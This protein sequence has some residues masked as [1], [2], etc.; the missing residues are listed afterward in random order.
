MSD[1]KTEIVLTVR[2][3][4]SRSL[5]SVLCD[6]MNKEYGG[7]YMR[8]TGEVLEFFRVLKGGK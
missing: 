3:P 8:Q 6:A 5:L 2:L 7:L 1:E 4:I